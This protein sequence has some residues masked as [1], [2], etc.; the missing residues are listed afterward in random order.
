MRPVTTSSPRCLAVAAMFGLGLLVSPA[1]SQGAG[2]P[3]PPPSG[4][5]GGDLGGPPV[6]PGAHE[7][8]GD[9]G[10][11][12]KPGRRGQGGAG[13]MRD[14]MMA[15][16][17]WM[18]TFN[19]MKPS[20][21]DDQRSKAEGIQKEFEARS[22]E[23]REKNGDRA[24][25][26]MKQMRAAREGGG[27]VD[28]TLAAELEKL[29]QSRPKIEDAQ[30]QIFALLTPEQQETFKKKLAENE[31]DEGPSRRPRRRPGRGWP[32]WQGPRREGR[33]GWQ[34]WKGWRWRCAA[35]GRQRQ[36][37]A[38]TDGS[39]ISLRRTHQA[40]AAAREGSR[41]ALGGWGAAISRRR[42]PGCRRSC[43]GSRGHPSR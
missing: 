29:N 34:G 21:N 14:R 1:F 35:E 5:G 42:T 37:A 23:W 25:E 26:L 28:P 39:V 11:Q 12:G 32:R 4:K 15:G 8:D 36:P 40:N 30:K 10:G 33:Q 27:T 13:D 43:R 6:P 31:Q 38:A 24:Q 9:F 22:K 41:F 17:G 7:G 20:L 2:S 19:E 3:P 16:R 18:M